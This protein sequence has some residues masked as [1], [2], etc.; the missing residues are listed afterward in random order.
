MLLIC[1]EHGR[2]TEGAICLQALGLEA[3]AGLW[4][5][6]VRK[7]WL[8]TASCAECPNG[9][10]LEFSGRLAALNGLL[11][12][13]GLPVLDAVPAPR[14]LPGRMPQLG[15]DRADPARRSFLRM[16]ASPV[17][18]E[19]PAGPRALARLQGL[20]SQ[21]ARATPRCAFVPVLDPAQCNA[22][23]ACTRLCPEG[24][25]ILINANAEQAAYQSDATRCTGCGICVAAC[26][27]DAIQLEVMIQPPGGVLPLL[28]SQCR[29]CGLAFYTPGAEAPADGLCPVCARVPHFR[30]LHQ[31]LT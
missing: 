10:G 4:L 28:Q 18:S 29:G 16:V 26:Q 6:G 2:A 22:C 7:L 15:E 17:T 24:A 5:R 19:A 3:L 25:L 27:E 21:R 30:K 31:V 13:R 20:Q 14:Q 9:K 23:H 12:D 1:P 8:A 11:A